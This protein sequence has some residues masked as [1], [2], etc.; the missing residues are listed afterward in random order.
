MIDPHDAICKFRYH[1]EA[2]NIMWYAKTKENQVGD[3]DT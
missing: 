3:E 1:I 2:V